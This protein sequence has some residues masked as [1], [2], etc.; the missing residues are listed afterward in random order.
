[1]ISRTAPCARAPPGSPASKAAAP[2]PASTP[3]RLL[4]GAQQPQ[5]ATAGVA[6]GCDAPGRQEKPFVRRCIQACAIFMASSRSPA[7]LAVPWG[8][9]ATFR[10]PWQGAGCGLAAT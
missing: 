5:P 8:N 2:S 3:R 7:A 1:M 6:P 10:P 9:S 4:A